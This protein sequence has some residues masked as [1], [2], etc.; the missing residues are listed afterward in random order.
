MY[1][2]NSE[3]L[4]IDR[5][6]SEGHTPVNRLDLMH[7]VLESS[8]A[9]CVCGIRRCSIAPGLASMLDFGSVSPHLGQGATAASLLV[10]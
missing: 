1:K 9:C 6:A 10:F 3:L 4:A 8:F 5:E 7:S 2:S